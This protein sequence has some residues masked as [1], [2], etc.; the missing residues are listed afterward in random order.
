ME[1]HKSFPERSPTELYI[2]FCNFRIDNLKIVKY[3]ILLRWLCLVVIDAS[4]VAAPCGGV[5]DLLSACA[6]MDIW[7]LSE[8][9]K[10]LCGA[11]GTC[12]KSRRGPVCSCSCCAPGAGGSIGCA[13]LGKKWNQPQSKRKQSLTF[14]EVPLHF[15]LLFTPMSSSRTWNILSTSQTPLLRKMI[16]LTDH[17]PK[18]N[19]DEYTESILWF[20]LFCERSISSA[21]LVY[22]FCITNLD[23]SAPNLPHSSVC[24]RLKQQKLVK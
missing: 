16:H 13:L 4:P 6:S 8:V 9:A 5:P 22:I 2:W 12:I 19:S 7:G 24:C 20:Y 14:K 15:F 23:V 10:P 3:F 11:A 18:K 1:C 17:L 21:K